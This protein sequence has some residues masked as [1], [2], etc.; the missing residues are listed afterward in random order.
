MKNILPDFTKKVVVLS[1]PTTD[2]SRSLAYPHWEKQGGR[3]FLASVSPEWPLVKA[4]IIA[5]AAFPV[6]AAVRDFYE[7]A[8]RLIE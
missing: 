3:L 5:G 6:A 1:F 4:S 8:A 7:T 2:G